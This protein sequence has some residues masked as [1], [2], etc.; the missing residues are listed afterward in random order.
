M[1]RTHLN[2]FFDYFVYDVFLC[3]VLSIS[4]LHVA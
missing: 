2:M 1:T 4:M 3:T